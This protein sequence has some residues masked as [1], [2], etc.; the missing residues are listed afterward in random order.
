MKTACALA[1]STFNDD[2][3]SLAEAAKTLGVTPT[4]F[5][6]LCQIDTET[7]NQQETGCQGGY[8][9][10]VEMLVSRGET[11]AMLSVALLQWKNLW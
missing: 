1:V 2:V 4:F 10:I 7:C 8:L 11:S 5:Y 9:T 3:S 6:K